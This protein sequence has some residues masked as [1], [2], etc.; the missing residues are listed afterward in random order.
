[1]I[2]NLPPKPFLKQVSEWILEHY[3]NR[4]DELVI[5]IPGQRAKTFLTMYL[6]EGSNQALWAPEVLSI[7]QWIEQ[8]LLK[9]IADPITLLFELYQ[10]YSR[11]FEDETDIDEFLNWGD[12]ILN[13]F[14]EIDMH[15]VNVDELYTNVSDYQ[16]L[17]DTFEHLSS[18]QIEAIHSFWEH[19][20]SKDENLLT[21]PFLKLWKLAPALYQEFNLRLRKKN[22]CYEGAAFREMATSP[23]KLIKN[24]KEY[25]FLGFNSL[26]P[27]EKKILNYL[28]S[29]GKAYFFWD[30]DNSYLNNDWHEAGRFLRENLKA[31]PPPN[32]FILDQKGQTELNKNK[33]FISYEFPSYSAQSR[34]A[35]QIGKTA[36]QETILRPDK[37]AFILPEENLLFPFLQHFPNSKSPIN[38]TMGYGLKFSNAAGFFEKILSLTKSSTTEPEKLLKRYLIQDC[39]RHD[40]L[41]NLESNQLKELDRFLN[42]QFN[43][44]L[45]LNDI[46][47]IVPDYA[48][49]FDQ[50][51]TGENFIAYLKK[52]AAW[53]VDNPEEHLEQEERNFAYQMLLLI[54]KL[55]N[56]ISQF[57][58]VVSKDTIARLLS[59]LIKQVRI[60]FVG[61][62][63]KGIQIMGTLETRLLDFEEVIILSCNEDSFPPASNKP[64]IIPF[65][66]KKGFGLPTPEIQDAIHAYHFYRLIQRAQ[67]VHLLYSSYNQSGQKSEASRYLAQL[68]YSSDII[69]KEKKLS[70]NVSTG[71]S[72]IITIPKTDKDIALLTGNDGDNKPLHLSPSGINTYIDCSLKFYF[73][74]LKKIK[75]PEERSEII[76]LQYFG[77]IVHETLKDLYDKQDL[78]AEL[79][80]KELIKNT[81]RHRELLWN[82]FINYGYASKKKIFAAENVLIF[83]NMLQYL[84]QVLKSDLKMAPL[85][86]V[87][88]EKRYRLGFMLPNEE[89]TIINIAGIIDR[90]DRLGNTYRIIDYKTGK[91]SFNF[92]RLEDLFDSELVKRNKA[93]FQL[94]VYGLLLETELHQ[95]NNNIELHLFNL[96]ELFNQKTGT[97][98]KLSGKDI[99][100]AELKHDFSL[101]LSELFTEMIN[102][103]IPFRQT[104]E[105]KTCEYC[106]FRESC[107]R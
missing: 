48:F 96:K 95:V 49:L 52:I 97:R 91:D 43:P 81:D 106:E 94:L 16:A 76:D 35:A 103:D 6:A 29:S 33:E 84:G 38:I 13:D 42:R 89:H 82:K 34:Y 32:D 58:V 11:T 71:N 53:L 99:E 83:E 22:I 61:E 101:K 2:T 87:S 65:S 50:T 44:V 75:I 59:K 5:V 107:N 15:L 30:Y 88:L 46:Q 45:E 21:E 23:E 93:A 26:T 67:K 51:S 20:K 100:F 1:M 57:E 41:K 70:P 73:R 40:Y 25:L 12:N 36:N 102:P 56:L 28:K 85:T 92:Q 37:L 17:S 10:S 68:K 3:P 18:N 9:T 64:G 63:L 19:F 24:D 31:F 47:A 4:T 60:P 55:E 8:S 72:R 77:I 105:F 104:K 86:I 66:L 62:P 7:Q 14:Q 90:V 79:F 80:L 98:I 69:L 54:Q 74:Y 39:L 78:L 27:S